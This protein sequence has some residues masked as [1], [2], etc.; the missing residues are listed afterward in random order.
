MVERQAA[1]EAVVIDPGFWRG[2]RVFLTGHTGFKGGWAALVMR[3]AGAEVTGFS[4]EPEY[5]DGIFSVAQVAQDV[6][7]VIG[8]IRE[9]RAL[10]AVID[11]AR[12]QIVVHMAAQSLV[13]R[14]YAAPVET[15]AANV[16]GT[17][18]LLEAVRHCAGV[19]AVIVVTSDKC[20]ENSGHLH[21][22]KE[23][24]PLGGSDPYSSS[25]ACA[26]IVTQAYRRSF[27][28]KS[29]PVP[30][31]SVRA[32]NVI[33]GGD[34][35]EDR[36]VPDAMRAFLNRRALHV[37]NPQSLR[38]WQHVLD[39]VLAYMLLTER[40][41]EDG[42]AF[43]EAWN[44]GP[45]QESEVTVRQ[46][47]DLL[48]RGWGEG[49]T[50]RHDTDQHPAEAAVLKLDCS[51][52][53]VRLNWRPMLGL[54]R[55]INLTLDW[56]RAFQRG[57]NMRQV[58]LSQIGEVVAAARVAGPALTQPAGVRPSAQASS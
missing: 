37:R 30:V 34:W 31:A 1:L 41:V 26:E 48:V 11:E 14:S 8:D 50:W 32:G 54:E 43:A 22:Y 7:H 24:E 6:R 29:F 52:A 17:V 35:A 23:D 12:P 39:P 57:A 2:R 42:A 28:D 33:G 49:V 44:F 10:R 4:L 18:H 27:F 16:M 9:P 36:L 51:K 5:A 58:T 56:Y 45:G 21:G 19:Q 3:S 13:R 46:I 47:V 40:L 38:P 25:K 15:Y 20:Y 55:S 53:A